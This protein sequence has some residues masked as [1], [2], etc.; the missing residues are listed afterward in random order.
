MSQYDRGVLSWSSH[1]ERE[2]RRRTL[3]QEK[4]IGG[5]ASEFL[6]KRMPSYAAMTAPAPAA[7]T[8][9]STI[10]CDGECAEGAALSKI[11]LMAGKATLSA[12]Q[13]KRTRKDAPSPALSVPSLIA[14]VASPATLPRAPVAVSAAPATFSVA[15]PA[16]EP[17]ALVAVC[18]APAAASVRLS[19]TD[20]TCEAASVASEPASE[21]A[22][23]PSL[24]TH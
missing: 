23:A 5:L 12:C 18:A 14:F 24:A 21:V 19:Y 4:T 17:T 10:K 8:A 7:T 1:P 9:P 16:R 13:P 6:R 2:T 22:S 11:P 15:T 20:S 3:Q